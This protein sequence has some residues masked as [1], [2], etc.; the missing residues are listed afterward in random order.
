MKQKLQITWIL[1]ILAITANSQNLTQTIRGQVL[2]I[3]SKSTLPEAT[4]ILMDSDP[5]IGTSTDVDGYY[6]LENVPI[7]RISIQAS[8]TGYEPNI[9]NNIELTSGKELILNF[10]MTEQVISMETIVVKAEDDKIETNNEMV[11]VSGRQFT[12]EESMRYAGARNDV[13]RMA[14]NFAGVRGANDAVNDI[15]IRG[16]SPVGVL[17]R[18][19]GI[20]IPNPN[21]FG[22]FGSTGGPVSM[23]NNNVLSNSDFLTGAF[24]AE[25]GNGISGVFDLK[26]RNGNYEK[27]EFLGQLGLNG[28]EVGAEGPI[29]RDKKSSY[30]LNYRYSTL[31]LMSA[32]GINFGTGTAIPYYQDIS[33]KLNMPTKSKG[34]FSAFG[35]GGFSQIDLIS[36]NAEDTIDNLYNNDLDIYV[37]TKM[38]VVG[39]SHQYLINNSSYTKF[40]IAASSIINNQVIDSISVETFEPVEFYRQ[41]FAQ[42]KISGNFYYKKKFNAKN[43]LQVGLRLDEFF[44]DITDSIFH[45]TRYTTLSDF[46]G[47]TLLIQ[48]YAQYQYRL[49]EK[50]TVNTGLH[51]QYLALNGSSSL[52]PRFGIKYQLN[53]LNAISFGYGLHS[54]MAP[55]ATYFKTVETTPGNYL[56]P[57][58]SIDFVKAHHF[59]IGY[60]RQ[61]SETMRVK[62]EIYYQ[63]LYDVLIDKDSSSFSVLNTGSFSFGTPDFLVNKGT[64]TNYGAELTI[65]KFLDKGLYFLI[66]GSLYKSKYLGSDGIE[67]ETAF[68]GNYV[69]NIVGGKEFNVFVQRSQKSKKSI[70]VDTKFTLAGG[71][72]YTPIDIDASIESNETVYD[73]SRA[74]TE[75]FDDYL[76]WDVR[77]AFKINGKSASQEFAIDVQNV[78]NRQNPLYQRF[79]PIE[80]EIN[81]V[82]QL[83]VFPVPQYRITF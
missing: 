51:F 56:T 32:V 46:N 76:R 8:Y 44:V 59:V 3:Q 75:Q 82:Y 7:G 66:T 80:G 22:D 78:T 63:H 47:S 61:L 43:N 74:F 45:G 48:P 81:T 5:V 4:V 49:T 34:T 67:R 62:A 64:G 23:L 83:G 50:L 52:E 6:T 39:I 14:Q 26:M 21:H 20:D 73:W 58:D 71:Q 35:I 79:N 10:E 13:S 17:W 70:V 37:R 42:S 19:E 55:I 40:T 15:I 11:A 53:D 72:R 24:P 30:L 57:N 60:D 27:H 54:I 2:D 38:G 31:G 69:A 1:A 36:S 18:L 29:N 68:S 12:I 41:H 25:Y 77:L 28:F 65:E 16:N 9:I 33:F